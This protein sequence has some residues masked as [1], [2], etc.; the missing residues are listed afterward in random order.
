MQPALTNLVEDPQPD[1]KIWDYG[2]VVVIDSLGITFPNQVMNLMINITL[3]AV[4]K[5]LSSMHYVV[6]VV[7]FNQYLC[8]VTWEIIYIVADVFQWQ[9]KTVSFSKY[10]NTVPKQ[11]YKYTLRLSFSLIICVFWC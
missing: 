8:F 1:S 10:S 11:H 6:V 2:F 9:Q 4:S 3:E 5:L 7:T